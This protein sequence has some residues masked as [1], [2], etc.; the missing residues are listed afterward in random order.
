MTVGKNPSDNEFK[1]HKDDKYSF[2]RFEDWKYDKSNLIDTL[3]SYFEKKPL[4]QWFSSFEPIL[5]GL[6]SSYYKNEAINNTAIHTD[7]CSPIATNPTWR[8]LS[9]VNQNLLFKDGIIIWKQLIEELQPDIMLIS[10][11]QK[12]FK[13]IITEKGKLLIFFDKKK[14]NTLRKYKYVLQIQF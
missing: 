3:N 13:E 4:K 10:V 8:K 9:I 12:L 7:I 6:N 5:N 14:D 11:P 1:L 2:C